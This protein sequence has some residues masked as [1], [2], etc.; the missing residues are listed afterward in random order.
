MDACLF[1]D[2]II[3]HPSIQKSFCVVFTRARHMP[4]HQTFISIHPRSSDAGHSVWGG[5]SLNP[6]RT[7]R[8]GE[9]RCCR[10]SCVCPAPPHVPPP[11]RWAGPERRAAALWDPGHHQAAGPTALLAYSEGERGWCSDS[12]CWAFLF[13][14]IEK[15][16]GSGKEEEI[17]SPPE[18]IIL[19]ILIRSS[20]TRTMLQFS[21]EHSACFHYSVVVI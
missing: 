19:S 2:C 8:W 14:L 11:G 7:S 10:A 13:Y 6:R 12:L 21:F 20:D 1:I 5:G 16:S 17:G 3:D 18:T 4:L 9:G 15:H